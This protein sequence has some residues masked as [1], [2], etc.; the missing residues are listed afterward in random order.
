MLNCLI[1]NLKLWSGEP[2]QEKVYLFP[3]PYG[4]L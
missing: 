3:K 1:T 4:G 2:N